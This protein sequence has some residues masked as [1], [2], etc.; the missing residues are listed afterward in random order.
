MHDVSHRVTHDH[1]GEHIVVGEVEGDLHAGVAAADDERLLALV[2]LAG[3]VVAGVHDLALER[4]DALD[5]RQHGLGVLAGGDDKPPGPVLPGA[6]AEDGLLAVDGGGDDL[7]GAHGPEL[8]VV[9]GA[10]DVLPAHGVDVVGHGVVLE[11]VEELLPGGVLGEALREGHHRQLAEALGQMQLEPEVRAVAPQ[12]GDAVV[13]LQQQVLDALH[14]EARRHSQPRRP[15]ANDHRTGD[16]HDV[17]SADD[18][19]AG[20]RRRR[21]PRPAVQRVVHPLPFSLV[22]LSLSLSLPPVKEC[23]CL[24]VCYA[25]WAGINIYVYPLV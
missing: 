3:A 18:G 14:G 9:L 4:L 22:H 23:L 6:A 16:V 24:V 13:P 11:V 10:D 19:E 15:R 21:A 2:S 8:T 25:G 17:T 20:G 12:R 5:L 7:L 1:G